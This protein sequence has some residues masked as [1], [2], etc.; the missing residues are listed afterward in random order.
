VQILPNGRIGRSPFHSSGSSAAGDS[1]RGKAQPGAV[2]VLDR[3]QRDHE[4]ADVGLRKALAR[5]GAN[6]DQ[7]MRARANALPGNE[8]HEAAGS[9][10]ALREACRHARVFAPARQSSLQAANVC[11]GERCLAYRGAALSFSA[12]S[13]ARA[14]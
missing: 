10:V 11:D 2:G 9:G 6:C 5:M 8:Q 7:A 1:L 12:K 3:R 14:R 4:L 13:R